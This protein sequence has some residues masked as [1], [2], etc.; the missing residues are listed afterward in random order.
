MALSI[1]Q[2]H[3]QACSQH[4]ISV[5]Y[6]ICTHTTH[7][8]VIHVRI[9]FQDIFDFK[10]QKSN[11]QSCWSLSFCSKQFMTRFSNHQFSLI[12][13]VLD[14]IFMLKVFLYI[15]TTLTLQYNLQYLLL[16]HPIK[17]KNIW[18]CQCLLYKQDSLFI[19]TLFYSSEHDTFFFH[20]KHYFN[21]E[22]SIHDTF[23]I[24]S[25]IPQV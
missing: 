7:K 19:N 5:F 23:E 1:F 3:Y 17:K 8:F 20:P 22:L 16:R 18:S 15:K 4:A 9:K 2:S 25:Y 12:E 24:L 21:S 10:E 6:L 14:F 11:Y 13:A